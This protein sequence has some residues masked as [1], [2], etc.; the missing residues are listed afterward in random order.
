MKGLK[1]QSQWKQK[2]WN[3]GGI[4]ELFTGEIDGVVCHGWNLGFSKTYSRAQ[5]HRT[6]KSQRMEENKEP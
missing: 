5:D 2:D 6:G 1:P 3:Q 4:V